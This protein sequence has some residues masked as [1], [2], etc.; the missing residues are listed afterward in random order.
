MADDLFVPLAVGNGDAR[1]A[2]AAARSK[3]VPIVPVP[4]DAPQCEWRHPKH[5]APVAMW[6]YRDGDGRLVGYA[7]RVD[8]DGA[9]GRQAKDVLPIAYCRIEQGGSQ[10]HSWRARALP[11]PRPL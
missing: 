1:P 4:A 7:A 9:D 3:L 2:R 5:G 10:R 6:L 8:Y 11:A